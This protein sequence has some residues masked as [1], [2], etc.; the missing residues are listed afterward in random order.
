V[1][2]RSNDDLL[3]VLYVGNGTGVRRSQG[4]VSGQIKVIVYPSLS[5]LARPSID[6]HVT[7][8]AH[9][10]GGWIGYVLVCANWHRDRDSSKVNE[11]GWSST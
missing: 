10:C 4:V 8:Y 6:T 3:N 5:P 9:Y 2:E 7:I 1:E 11:E